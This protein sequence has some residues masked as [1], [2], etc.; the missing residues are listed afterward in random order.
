MQD[1]EGEHDVKETIARKAT[2]AIAVLE[3]GSLQ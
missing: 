1:G 2:F 3:L